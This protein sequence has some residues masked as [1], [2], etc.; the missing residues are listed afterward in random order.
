MKS[1]F[2]PIARYYDMFHKGI[3]GDLEFYKKEASKVGTMMDIGCGTGRLSIPIAKDGTRVVG[4]DSSK[5]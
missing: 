3:K 4:I 2:D 5:K 1:E